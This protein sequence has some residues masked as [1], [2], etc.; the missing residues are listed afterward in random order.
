MS[1]VVLLLVI[2][3]LFEIGFVLCVRLGVSALFFVIIFLYQ[4]DFHAEESDLLSSRLLRHSCLFSIS[5]DSHITCVV[6]LVA[7]PIF[8]VF[9]KSTVCLVSP[10]YCANDDFVMLFLT[11]TFML[12]FAFI[13]LLVCSISVL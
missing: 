12:I 8:L 11:A 9:S 3:E 10:T 1:L 2:N 6:V 7:A 5:I 4:I 13:I